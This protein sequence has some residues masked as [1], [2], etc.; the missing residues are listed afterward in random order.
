[1]N[2]VRTYTELLTTCEVIEEEDPKKIM[3]W[4]SKH[5]VGAE[6]EAAS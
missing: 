6:E 2:S 3:K 4:T 5:I 1:M